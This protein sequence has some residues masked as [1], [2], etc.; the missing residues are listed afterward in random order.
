MGIV[1]SYEEYRR[2]P[3]RVLSDARLVMEGKFF[4]QQRREK[5]SSRTSRRGRRA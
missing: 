5:E 3:V 2:L 4:D 1:Q